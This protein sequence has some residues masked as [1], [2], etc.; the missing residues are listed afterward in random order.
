MTSDNQDSK[1]KKFTSKLYVCA[2]LAITGKACII[3]M[4]PYYA[5]SLNCSSTQYSLA[6]TVYYIA[7]QV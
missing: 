4:G 2:L 7:M 6:F 5:I 3:P 1:V